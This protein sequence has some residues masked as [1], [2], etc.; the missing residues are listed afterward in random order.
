VPTPSDRP[1]TELPAEIEPRTTDR[2]GRSRAGSA[3]PQV[4]VS[5]YDPGALQQL[6]QRLF[7][8][9][10]VHPVRDGLE[11]KRRARL[12]ERC[13]VVLDC[14]AP[15]LDPLD[16]ARALAVVAMPTVV[17]WGASPAMKEKLAA[18]SGSA[19][20]VHVGVDTAPAALAELISSFC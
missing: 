17:V 18:S 5:T 3:L 12:G 15:E 1:T 4:V 16:V 2:P 11:L 13:V 8:R 19:K 9:A 7:G 14:A 10:E 20:W 6:K